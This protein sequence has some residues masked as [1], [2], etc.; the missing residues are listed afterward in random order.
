MEEVCYIY[1]SASQRG[2]FPYNLANVEHKY[3]IIELEVILM[4]H[5]V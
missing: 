3:D 1:L 4:T 5:V 2:I